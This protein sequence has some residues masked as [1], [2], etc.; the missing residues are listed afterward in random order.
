MLS[1]V[2]GYNTQFW[3]YIHSPWVDEINLCRFIC[4]MNDGPYTLVIK[5]KFFNIYI[6]SFATIFYAISIS[7]TCLVSKESEI[8]FQ[9]KFR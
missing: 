6:C 7:D 2:R 8:Y 4:V 3:L 5:R 1:N 9:T